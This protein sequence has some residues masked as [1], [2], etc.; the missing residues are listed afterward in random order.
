MAKGKLGGGMTVV[1]TL[2]IIFNL[3]FLVSISAKIDSS[4]TKM[5]SLPFSTLFDLLVKYIIMNFINIF[6]FSKKQ[7]GHFMHE[8][9]SKKK[10]NIYIL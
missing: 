2:V 8:W 7:F 6:I 10:R 9:S 4:F 3:V 1:K 5:N